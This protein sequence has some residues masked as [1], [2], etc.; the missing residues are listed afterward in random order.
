[1]RE[2]KTKKK[3]KRQGNW[4]IKE[5][6]VCGFHQLSK[7]LY[8]TLECV[9]AQGSHGMTTKEFACLLHGSHDSIGNRLRQLFFFGLI[10]KIQERH[11]RQFR[12]RAK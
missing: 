3:V 6:P 8:E 10:E 4:S 9:K 12:W 7:T 5:C 11:W 1:M 2:M